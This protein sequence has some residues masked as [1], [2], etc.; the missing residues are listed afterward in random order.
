MGDRYQ[1]RGLHANVDALLRRTFDGGRAL[2]G[3]NGGPPLDWSGEMYLWRRAVAKAW[4]TPPREIALLRLNRAEQLG[5]SYRAFNAVLLDRGRWLNTI[6][7]SL[8]AL[9]TV[10]EF[11]RS[12]DRAPAFSAAVRDKFAALRNADI[13]VL[14]DKLR[15]RRLTGN[16]SADEVRTQLNAQLGD[17][18]TGVELLSGTIDGAG[19]GQ[20]CIA[21]FLRRNG[22]V[23]GDAVMVGSSL[24]DLMLAEQAGLSLFLW[25]DEY[26]TAP[27]AS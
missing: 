24:D 11:D 7:F 16:R 19:A 20:H 15:D 2:L 4:K 13:L 18:I 9:A 12:A 27:E 8:S 5:L 25:A 3:H 26:F 6:V 17:K 22:R 23:A 14:G 21:E 10:T 1:S